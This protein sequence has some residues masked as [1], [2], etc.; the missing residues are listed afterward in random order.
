MLKY[1]KQ[2]ERMIPMPKVNDLN[3]LRP[4]VKDG[5][6]KLKDVMKDRYNVSIIAFETFRD[7]SVQEAYYA[8]GR[9]P[10]TTVNALRVN[11]GLYT[12]GEDQNKCIITNSKKSVYHGT[13]RAVDVCLV[14]YEGKKQILWWDAPESMWELIGYEAKKLGF[15]W[16]GDFRDSKG[17]MMKDYG[18]LQKE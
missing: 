1:G 7:D 16:G 11:A 9:M 13:G 2:K 3:L 6:L 12:I 8:Q 5:F 4:D 17:R 10:L 15:V 14:R 18:H